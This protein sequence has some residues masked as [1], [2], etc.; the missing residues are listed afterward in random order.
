[1]SEPSAWRLIRN[2]EG[3]IADLT[4]YA[5]ALLEGRMAGRYLLSRERFPDTVILQGF[6][7]K[8]ILAGA[9]V[10]LDRVAADAHG[11]A[12][13]RRARAGRGGPRPV[14]TMALD[15]L[16]K[17]A[18][19]R[20]RPVSRPADEP[21]AL[22]YTAGTTGRAKGV[23]LTHRNFAAQCEL[24]ETLLTIEASDRVALVLPL[25]HIY[26][27][28]N[29]LVCGMRAGATL[30]LIPQYSPAKL[31]ETIER[32]G[33]TVL[34]AIPTMYEHLLALARSRD[35]VLARDGATCVSPLLTLA[36]SRDRVLPRSLRI[37]ISGGAPLPEAVLRAFEDRFQTRIIE[38]YGLTETTSA[39]CLNRPGDAFKAGSVGPPSPG[40]NL[41]AVDG[42]G[43]VCAPG[44]TGEIQI[45]GDTVTP[46]Y[47][48][49]PESTGEAIRDGWL[50]TGD[51]GY[52][53]GDGFCFVTDRCK[54]LIIR[55][56]FNV[57]PRE[58][59]D[60][61]LQ[62]PGIRDA[63]AVGVP[64]R[65]GRETIK[66]AVVATADRSPSE[67]ELIAF[68]S[69]RLA[70]YKVP[71]MVE[72]HET[73]PRSATGKLLRK[74]L[75]P[76]FRDDRLLGDTPAADA[77]GPRVPP[78]Q[79][80][81]HVP[82]PGTNGAAEQSGREVPGLGTM[83]AETVRRYKR[84]E[85]LW[86]EGRTMTWRELDEQAARFA[87]GLSGLGIGS[88]DRVALML[89]NVPAFATCFFGIQKL[90]AIAVPFN[91]MYKGREITHI[92]TDS[93]AR[94]LVALA[95]FAPLIDEIRED[96]PALEHVILTGERTLVYVAPGRILNMQAVIGR[97]HFPDPVEAFRAIGEMLVRMLAECGV[98]AT[99]KH[100]GGV[101]VRGRKIAS[102]L[103][104]TTD[105]LLLIHAMVLLGRMD[106]G[107]MFRVVWA[108]PEIKG[109]ILEP[110]TSV[111]EETG[112]RP[113]F[114]AAAAVLERYI[115]ETFGVSLE[116]GGLKRDE[117][118]G[119]EKALSLA[120]RAPGKRV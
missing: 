98:T 18:S 71:K 74:E 36:R 32:A 89:P 93:G 13:A 22:I 56:G 28:A 79:E 90:G 66:L 78:A 52:L 60:V 95:S 112:K 46:G 100:R 103:V 115:R 41:R 85:A 107:D 39:V 23:I 2:P 4:A 111:E 106:A 64:D 119:Y 17:G 69:E 117:K 20:F 27:L 101:R 84:R 58:I 72:F 6:A 54:D 109:K 34:I 96:T 81:R 7:E 102:V 61:A 12:V 43:R 94:V 62:H 26:G 63:A 59:E 30:V 47:W 88:G 8:G 76:D 31:L 65:Q 92:L 108:P 99:Y 120:G 44:V 75:R 114:A 14:G 67:R 15:D 11:I 33:I 87:H 83:I 82:A 38:G 21:A 70:D 24:A 110:M 55:G 50:A 25:F 35:R 19:R 10:T 16:L 97:E 40:L 113:T 68:C 73:L 5:A 49:D 118:F 91:T 3:R 57:S 45:K 9:D 51:L 1:M 42:D 29:G 105:N 116:P 80:T 53:D 104:S 37:C 86:H 77:S 48:N